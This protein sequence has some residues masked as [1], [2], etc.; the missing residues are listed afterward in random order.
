MLPNIHLSNTITESNL[1]ANLSGNI[2]VESSISR[3]DESLASVFLLWQRVENRLNKVLEIVWLLE[4][5]NLLSEPTS[6]WLL[7]RE[8][9]VDLDG[10]DLR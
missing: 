1:N 4:D 10:H 6:S 5:L 9:G 2:I 8:W 7:V 3:H